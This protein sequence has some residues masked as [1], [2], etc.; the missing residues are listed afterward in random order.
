[1]H[2]RLHLLVISIGLIIPNQQF[3]DIEWTTFLQ[4]P[5]KNICTN[6]ALDILRINEP[7]F[8]IYYL[9]LPRSMK[10]QI[11]TKKPKEGLVCSTIKSCENVG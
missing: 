3:S 8:S 1:M 7:C 2:L 11:A 4:G 10:S 5:P 9:L 6:L